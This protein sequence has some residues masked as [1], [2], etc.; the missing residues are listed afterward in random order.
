MESKLLRLIKDRPRGVPQPVTLDSL[1]GMKLA[2]RVP[3][4]V[5]EAAAQKAARDWIAANG[6]DKRPD[7]DDLREMYAAERSYR[8]A[9]ELLRYCLID[10]ETGEPAAR[11]AEE[12]EALTSLE[13]DHLYGRLMEL[14]V[15]TAPSTGHLKP[16]EINALV[17]ELGKGQRPADWN[18]RSKSFGRSTLLALLHGLVNRLAMSGGETSCT[19]T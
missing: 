14:V 16:D 17:E 18:S 15:E 6:F 4:R 3:T 1:P 11:T 19:T 12:I 9:I 8:A 13:I 10:L 7:T 5:Q 2:L